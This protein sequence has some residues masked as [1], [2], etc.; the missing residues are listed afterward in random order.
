MKCF[1]AFR[2]L[3][4][5]IIINILY[6]K[7]SLLRISEFEQY[8]K[9]QPDYDNFNKIDKRVELNDLSSEE[10]AFLT[11]LFAVVCLWE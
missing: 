6:L 11:V 9:W 3:C 2:K 1:V 5:L 7:I 8:L 10:S 4:Y